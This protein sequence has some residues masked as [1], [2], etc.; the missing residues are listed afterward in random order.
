MLKHTERDSCPSCDSTEIVMHF[1][2][3]R[4]TDGFSVARSMFG[5]SI[6]V[7]GILNPRMRP[8][9]PT[10]AVTRVIRQPSAVDHGTTDTWPCPVSSG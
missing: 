5:L 10:R 3:S 4:V 6:Y 2:G 1:D 7:V 8:G 9:C